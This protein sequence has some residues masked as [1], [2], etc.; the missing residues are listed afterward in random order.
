MLTTTTVI[1][2][3]E[4]IT[5]PL[6]MRRPETV[7]QL[8]SAAE[9]WCVGHTAYLLAT[10]WHECSFDPQGLCA[11]PAGL[12]AAMQAGTLTGRPLAKYIL[13]GDGDPFAFRHCRK[14]VGDIDAAEDVAALA[15]QFANAIN[16]CGWAAT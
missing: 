1:L 11:D 4:E 10:A 14:V 7:M 5:G 2:A 3:L 16:A 12:A 13:S 8:L 9:G 15:V 6:A